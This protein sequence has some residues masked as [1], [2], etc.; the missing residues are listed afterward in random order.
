MQSL[1]EVRVRTEFLAANLTRG[2]VD[3]L[4]ALESFRRSGCATPTQWQLANR[5]ARSP[6]TVQRALAAARLLGLVVSEP[7]F[8]GRNG[9]QSANFYRLFV[10]SRGVVQV[11]HTW[12]PPKDVLAVPSVCT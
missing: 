5:S 12:R 6:R 1:F 8:Y 3:V 10:P 9:R 11:R 7:R 2:E 4:V